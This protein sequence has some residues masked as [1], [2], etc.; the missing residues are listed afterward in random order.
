M[1]HY[2]P[3]IACYEIITPLKLSCRNLCHITQVS[4]GEESHL[5]AP[6]S[7]YLGTFT[8]CLVN[9]ALKMS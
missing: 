7:A 3:S 8:K 9:M 2:C 4:R 6:S 5:C 1:L